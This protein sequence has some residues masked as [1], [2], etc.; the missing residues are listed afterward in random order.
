[1]GS[2]FSL[3]N[4]CSVYPQ[5]PPVIGALGIIA[6]GDL[7]SPSALVRWV[8]NSRDPV[9]CA[10]V[11][12]LHNVLKKSKHNCLKCYWYTAAILASFYFICVFKEVL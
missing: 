12:L 6:V 11:L 8:C 7:F 10:R 5:L 2:D 1:M 4:C 9:L 3:N